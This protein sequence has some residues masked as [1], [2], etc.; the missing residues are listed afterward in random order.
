EGHTNQDHQV[1][2]EKIVDGQDDFQD[3]VHIR[4][5]FLAPPHLTHLMRMRCRMLMM[6]L[7]LLHFVRLTRR[8]SDPLAGQPAPPASSTPARP[9][10]ALAASDQTGAWRPAVP[11]GSV[12]A[13]AYAVS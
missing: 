3:N 6:P 13:P 11:A 10:A 2:D 9:E 12:G 8:R 4:T 7:P 1:A 5:S